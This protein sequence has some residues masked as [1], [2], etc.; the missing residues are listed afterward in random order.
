MERSWIIGVGA[1]LTTAAALSGGV[2]AAKPLERGEFHEEFSEE[3]E[4]FCDVPGLTVQVDTV[5]DGTFRVDT[6]GRDGLVYFAEHLRVAGTFTNVANGNV[7]TSVDK[8]LNK[9]L[10]VI[11]NGDG[12]LT[13][14]LL[15]TGNAT[16]Y[17]ASG[18]AIGR[19]PGQVRF[20][21]L[22]DHAETPGDPSDDVILS[23]D[24]IKGSTGRSDDFCTV[25]VP[26]LT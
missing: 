13:V 25:L 4:N 18:K 14:T 20:E 2:A 16:L 10:K 21:F 5:V 17:D 15:A 6:H 8:V 26:V 1:V 22:I 12:T 11:D 9:D 19:N 7:A 24:L 23:E 3:V